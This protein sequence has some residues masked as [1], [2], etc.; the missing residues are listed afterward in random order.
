MSGRKILLLLAILMAGGL[1]EGAFSL[2]GHF[3]LGPSGCRVH[4]GRF[5]G[6]SFS[7]EEQRQLEIPA[8]GA[9]R[10]TNAFGSVSVRGGGPA[11]QVR[12]LLRKTVFAGPEARARELAGRVR[13]EVKQD[14]GGLE[15]GT[16]RRDVEEG[17]L[18]EAGLETHFEVEL[19]ADGRVA[20]T[21]EY[22]PVTVSG[23]AAV[24]AENAFEDLRVEDVAGPVRLQARRGD[25]EVS[26][27]RGPL[28]LVARHGGARLRD[29]AQA[30]I[31]V[32]NGDLLVEAVE[33]FTELDASRDLARA[34][35]LLESVDA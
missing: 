11:G 20:V 2:R 15:L 19:P 34:A 22:G 35:G 24:E 30:E 28:S 10:L 17:A 23:V 21:N 26:R 16:N 6:P 9:L 31:D 8:G 18:R 5:S 3:E 29:V 33:V 1:L 25:V 14:A 27:L 4:P 32:E 13:L 12:V 7:F